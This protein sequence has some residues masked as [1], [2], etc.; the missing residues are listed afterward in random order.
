MGPGKGQEG[1]K[2]G[3]NGKEQHPPKFL[4][5]HSGEELFYQSFLGRHCVWSV[6][7]ALEP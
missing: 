5:S 2:R 3:E 1:V 6:T 7:W 4:L